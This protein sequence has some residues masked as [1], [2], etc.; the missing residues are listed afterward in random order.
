VGAASVLEDLA[1]QVH[2][3]VASVIDPG[4]KIALLGYPN[5]TNPGDHAIWLGAKATFGRLGAEVIYECAW[6]DY[7]RAALGAA[8]KDGALIVF[9]GGGNFG[10]VWP[11]T[12][13]LRERVVEDFRDTRVVQLQQSV[14]FARPRNLARTEKL[15]RRHGNVTLVVRD[16]L[17][18]ELARRA[19]DVDIRLGP[20]LALAAPLS[21]PVDGPA[22]DIAWIARE[23]RESRGLNPPTPCGVWRMDWNLRD[24]ERRPIQDEAAPPVS[25]SDLVARNGALTKAAKPDWRALADVRDQ[26]T[27]VR[28]RR[29]CQILRRGRVVVTDSLHAHIL[30]VM[31]GIPTVATDNNNGKLRGTFDA[32]T[33]AVPL[34]RWADTPAEALAMALSLHVS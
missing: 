12:H 6:R 27:Q 7:S 25:L 15:L 8:V 14:H 31:L 18:L 30:G 21:A 11:A 32:F 13:S 24:N 28:L 5:H 20:D 23:D 16:R 34:A 19:F 33:R 10:D 1:G 26:L 2:R 29:G 9:T 22:T 3:T 4:S 17:S